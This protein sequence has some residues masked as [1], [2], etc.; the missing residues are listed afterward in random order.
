M[1]PLVMLLVALATLPTVSKAFA[2]NSCDPAKGVAM[3]GDADAPWTM[4]IELNPTEVP[5][6]L[7]FDA[8][9]TVCSLSDNLPTR[10]TVDATMPAHKHGMNYQPKTARTGDI[11][12]KATNLLFHMPGMWR[13]E[14]TAYGK[15][16][17]HRF[18]HDVNLR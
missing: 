18:T 2:E 8:D 7:P 15:D 4:Q 13:L 14:V 6:N 5:L 12:Y 10:I 17:P 3:V 9:V 16:K 11:S 1:K